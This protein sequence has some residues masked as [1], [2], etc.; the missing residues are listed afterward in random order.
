MFSYI[1]EKYYEKIKEY[2]YNE[3]ELKEIK[4]FES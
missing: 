3:E 4:D 1:M 2:Y